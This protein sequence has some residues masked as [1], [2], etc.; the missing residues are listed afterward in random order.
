MLR[1]YPTTC[2]GFRDLFRR[3]S[4][5][6]SYFENNKSRLMRSPCC[7]CTPLSLTV[8]FLNQSLWNSVCLSWHLRPTQWSTSWNPPVYH[9]L[10][11]RQR[12]GKNVT[13][14]TNTHATTE[15]LLDQLFYMR[16]ASYQRKV[17]DY[18]LPQLLVT[19]IFYSVKQ[20]EI[21]KIWLEKY[22]KGIGCGLI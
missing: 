13:A 9:L 21:C 11:P 7:L 8:K 6:F 4:A 20:Y 19:Y 16:F 15:E 18:V 22:V 2:I 5:Y 1:N 17:G 14:A 3:L 10:V 12:L